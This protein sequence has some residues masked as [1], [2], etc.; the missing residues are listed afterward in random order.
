MKI[1]NYGPKTLATI[2]YSQR[3]R[4]KPFSATLVIAVAGAFPPT[5]TT[6]SAYYELIG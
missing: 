5:K 3:E 1:K 6:A 2:S 4:L